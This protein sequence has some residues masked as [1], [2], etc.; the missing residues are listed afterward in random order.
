MNTTHVTAEDI[1]DIEDLMRRLQMRVENGELGLELVLLQL[2]EMTKTVRL[3]RRIAETVHEYETLLAHA[4]HDDESVPHKDTDFFTPLHDHDVP[5]EH[6]A[7]LAKYRALAI[8]YKVPSTTPICYRVRASFTLKHH[9][10]KA[11]P[12][13]QN[14]NCLQDRNFFDDDPTTNCLVFWVPRLVKNSTSKEQDQQMDLLSKLRTKLKLPAH[15]LVNFG[16]VSLVAGLILAHYKV[17]GECIPLN[18][19]WACTDT[20]EAGGRLILLWVEDDLDCQTWNFVVVGDYFAGV[21]A[22][23]IE[24]IEG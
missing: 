8:E 3:S 17:T 23:G 19:Y 24:P 14:F 10:P 20:C 22:L 7:V 11:G 6:Q 12:C 18:N 5:Q 15:H 9:A 1:R 4:V 21:F 2:E 16:S 13:H